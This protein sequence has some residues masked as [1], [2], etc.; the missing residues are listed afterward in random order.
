MKQPAFATLE[1]AFR[2]CRD[3]DAS[4]NERLEAFSEA[5]RYLIPGYQE[6]VDRM[7]DRLKVHEAGLSAPKAGEMMPPFAMPDEQGR[8]VTLDDLLHDGPL[9]MTFHRG[10]WCPYC[11]INT[12]ALV[13]V[14]ARIA[15]DGA[16]LAAI[17]PERQQFAAALKQDGEIR[18]PVLTDID[19][20]YALSLNLAVWVGDEM[21]RIL[22]AG[23]R[24]V[25]NYQGN[26]TCAAD[27][28]DLVVAQDGGHGSL[29]RSGLSQPHDDRGP[30]CDAQGALEG[31]R[32]QKP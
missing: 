16:H 23:G 25:A 2:H 19:N 3:M 6:A 28:R 31:E 27:P 15:A 12:R 1:E 21:Q 29:R 30:A 11:R 18:Y 17:M 4:L 10:H 8:L 7:V 20:G 26:Q 22:E 5:T 9:A 24:D 13:Q 32:E 14:Q